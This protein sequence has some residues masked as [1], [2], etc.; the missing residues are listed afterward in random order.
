MDNKLLS[1]DIEKHLVALERES[2]LLLF[3]PVLALCILPLSYFF[4]GFL[5]GY[6]GQNGPSI[7][8][9]IKIL[10][11]RNKILG[12]KPIRERTKNPSL[13]STP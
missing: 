12:Q 13:V 11:L 2:S 7:G 6:N 8:P 9:F 10:I 4:H 1:P 3:S 5:R